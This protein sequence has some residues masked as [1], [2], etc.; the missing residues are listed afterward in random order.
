MQELSHF[1]REYQG[2]DL[3]EEDMHE[4]AI[5]QFDNWFQKAVKSEK[6]DPNAMTLSTTNHQKEISSRVVLM[7]GYSDQGFIFFGHYKSKKGKQLSQSPKASLLFYWP[8]LIRQIRIEGTVSK[9]TSKQSDQYFS[10]RPKNSQIAAHASMQ[11]EKIKDRHTLEAQ[12]EKIAKAM[13]NI[14]ITRPDNWGGWILSP[15]T[16]E[17]WQG[18]ENRLHDRIEYFISNQTWCH[19]RLAP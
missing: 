3:T 18:R 19:R 16:L 14:Q 15:N 10:T 4:N 13:E 8:T 9:L 7:K 6:Y 2:H 11:S 12:Y 1:R 17:F 5:Q